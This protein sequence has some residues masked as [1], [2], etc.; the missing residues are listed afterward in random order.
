M[1]LFYSIFAGDFKKSIIM[2]QSNASYHL[3]HTNVT[4]GDLS[5]R[6]SLVSEYKE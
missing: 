2:P 3:G 1:S 4:L 6:I 5:S